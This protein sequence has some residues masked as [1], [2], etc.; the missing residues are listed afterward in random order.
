MKHHLPLLLLLLWLFTIDLNASPT[1]PTITSFKFEASKNETSISQD[2]ICDI[3]GDSLIISIIPFNSPILN[4]KAT[5]TTESTISVLANDIEQENGISINDFADPVY[6]TLKS[7]NNTEKKYRVELVYTGLP[8]VYINTVEQTPIVSKDLYVQGNLIIQDASGQLFSEPMEIKGR[9]NSTWGMPKKPYKI[10]LNTKASILGMP[11]DKEW[12]LLAN[13]ADKTL[14]RNYLA[15]KMGNQMN[16]AYTPRMQSVEVVL[17]GKHQGN[18]LLGEQIKVSSDRVNITELTETDI[19]EESIN[20]GYLLE[21]DARLDETYWFIT[22]KEVAITIKSPKDITGEQLEYIKNYMQQTENAI[23]SESYTSPETGYRQYINTESMIEW[24]WI[25]ELFKNNDAILHSSVYLYK[26][27]NDKLNF[28]PLWDFDI[29]AGNVN[30]NDNYTPSGWWIRKAPWIN[31]LLTDPALEQEFISRWNEI[32]IDIIPNILATLESKAQQLDQSQRL[33]FLKWPILNQ[34]VWPNAVVTGSY[35]N[36]VTYLQNWLKARI[37]WIDMQNNNTPQNPFALLSPENS[38]KISLKAN[39]TDT[40]SFSWN[41]SISGSSYVFMLDR[42][43][44][45]FS[46]PLF[47]QKANLFGSDTTV[48]LKKSDLYALLEQLNIQPGESIKLIWNIEAFGSID[49]K[50]ATL[51]REIELYNDDD[52]ITAGNNKV[53]N[54]IIL[55]PNPAKDQITIETSG[56]FKIETIELHDLS[57]RTL[58]KLSYSHTTQKIILDLNLYTKGTYQLFLKGHN[59]ERIVKKI[60][61][62]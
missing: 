56:D 7:P 30:Y 21:I 16:L 50:I 62:Y 28:G 22:D 15:L 3:Y 58:D 51:S 61:I 2:I 5:F 12:V 14:M 36:E 26:D 41:K 31:K 59:N 23:F 35:A 47:K 37:A 52:I 60:I 11:K 9:G 29:A 8:I 57:G 10:K 20:G 38:Y 49:Y 17:N 13:Y 4:L 45:Y 44:S 48:N 46:D 33:N 6:Y 40:V 25:N 24:Y 34:W 32:K 54:N 18:Y 27:R 19:D 42:V 53:N 1:N 39:D 43:D 55:Y